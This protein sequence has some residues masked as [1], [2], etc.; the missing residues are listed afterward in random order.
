MSGFHPLNRRYP[1][2]MAVI[3]NAQPPTLEDVVATLRAQADALRASG[4]EAL[5]VFGSVS[6]GEAG[7]GSDVDLLVRLR[8]PAGFFAYSRIEELLA[9]LL[10]AKVDVVP[11]TSLRP[12]IRARIESELC[13]VL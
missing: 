3:P 2:V 11:E 1:L 9:E 10:H 12:S 4:V 13:N 5:S 8:R 6:R 7:M